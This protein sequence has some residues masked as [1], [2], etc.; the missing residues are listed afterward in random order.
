MAHECARTL[1]H[2]TVVVELR[3]QAERATWDGRRRYKAYSYCHVYSICHA[4]V[5]A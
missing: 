3:G 1:G 5:V 4:K 2:D